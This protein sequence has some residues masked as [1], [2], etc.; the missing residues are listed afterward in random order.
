MKGLTYL[1]IVLFGALAV[2][3]SSYADPQSDNEMI[4]EYFDDRLPDVALEDYINGV[5]AIDENARLQWEDI[6]EFP[7]YEDGVD[8]GQEL[9]ETAFANGKSYADCFPNGGI[10]IKQDYP[11]FD[12]ETGQIVTLELAINQ[13]RTTHGEQA[14]AYGKGELAYVSAYM[15]FTS[16][17]KLINVTVPNDPRA[18]AA[19]EAGKKMFYARRGQLNMA[20]A[21]CHVN[22]AG[23]QL[24]AD[25]LSP[26]LGH[27]SH[28]PVFRFKWDDIGTLQRRYAG[29]NKQI[30]AKPFK[31]QS[32]TYRNLEYFHTHMSNG[33]A[34]NGP[35]SRK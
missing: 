35:G 19:Y 14:L 22:N 28:F 15:A 1:S 27:T 21:T 3:A 29:C 31:L 18:Q 24:R 16:R 2:N 23:N 6:E 12:Q 9:F 25:I 32:V 5:Y 13:C 34:I 26:A 33:L 8:Q 4:R 10:G 17:D 20:C 11:K 30:R 7:P